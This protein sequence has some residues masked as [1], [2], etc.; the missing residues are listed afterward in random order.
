MIS[1]ELLLKVWP[2]L[3][4]TKR[5]AYLF[6]N[7]KN[8]LTQRIARLGLD[9]LVVGRDGEAYAREMW[10]ASRTYRQGSQENL[11]VADNQTRRYES[12]TANAREFLSQVAW[13]TQRETISNHP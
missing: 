12:G 6:E 1:R 4:I 7:G 13:G 5:G 3:I 10:D 2:R 9:S 8:S 11:L